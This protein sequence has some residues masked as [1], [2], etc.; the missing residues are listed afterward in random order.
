MAN[1]YQI[2]R[3]GTVYAAVEASAYGTSVTLASTDAIR[4]LDVKMNQSSKNRVNSPERHA[5]PSQVYR[6][7]RRATADWLIRGILYPSGTLNTLC[8]NSALLESFFG[9]KTSVS[10]S[11]TIKSGGA[12]TTTADD[13]T[14]AGALAVGDAILIANND[15]TKSVVVLQ[16]VSSLSVTWLPALP[17]VLSDGNVVKG[18]VTYKMATAIP[19]TSSLN[20][21]HYLTSKSY[22]IRGGIPE[23]LRLTVDANDE[24]MWEMSGPAKNRTRNAQSKPGAFT[25]VGT[26]PPSGLTG[27]LQIGAT[28]EEFLKASFDLKNGFDVDNMAF[29][30]SETQAYFRKGK[31]EVSCV[32]DTMDSN[33]ITMED[34]GDSN[35]N[36][37]AMVQV[38]LTEGSI[39]GIWA[40]TL[41]LNEA[42]RA[43]GDETLQHSYRG[44]CKSVVA[45]NGELTLI[46]A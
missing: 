26:T 20:I 6:F 31:R 35:A 28:R 37:T 38:G 42:D 5:H 14:S 13:L 17:A 15:G 8:D 43:D 1:T 46:L 9:A 11:T 34:L 23:N 24:V 16:T 39:V 4:H 22:E 3:T 29:G 12:G 27:Y 18:C 40:P 30:T 10:L 32:L 7:N 2:G 41:E 36:T 25:V 21:A 33:D 45:G 19:A 44:L